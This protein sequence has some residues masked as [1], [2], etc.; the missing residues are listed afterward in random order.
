VVG[1]RFLG[2]FQHSL[3]AKGRVILPARFRQ[4]LGERAVLTT[5][6]DGCLAIW[7][8]EEFDVKASEMNERRKGGPAD[9]NVAR[10]FFADA[11]EFELTGQGRVNIPGTLRDFAGLT[12]N[13]VLTG[14]YD[15]VQIWDADK[16]RDAKQSGGRVL[17][18]GE[19]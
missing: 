10:A 11:V 13:V 2:E 17:A 19:A 1:G 14:Q 8:P 16:W 9:R 15:H 5:Q 4:I 3:D 6:D 18:A 7:T 12:Q